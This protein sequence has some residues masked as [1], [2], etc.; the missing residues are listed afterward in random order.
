MSLS[1]VAVWTVGL[2]I[3]DVL[4][5]EIS[6]ALGVRDNIFLNLHKMEICSEF[7]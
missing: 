3:F 2:E 6:H 7:K 4:T 5:V 1:I